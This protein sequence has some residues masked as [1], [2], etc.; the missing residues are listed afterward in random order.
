MTNSSG[1]DVF[2]NNIRTLYQQPETSF[3][4]YNEIFNLINSHSE[5][6]NA[7]ISTLLDN[8]LPIFTLP[9]YSLPYMACLYAIVVQ[10]NSQANQNSSVSPN[11]VAPTHSAN[12]LNLNDEQFMTCLENCIGSADKKQVN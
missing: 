2:I 7:N 4:N 8:V 12:N 1:L 3:I 6:L 9:E 11:S 5:V 10:L